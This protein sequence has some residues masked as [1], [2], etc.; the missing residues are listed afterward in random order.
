M[1]SLDRLKAQLESGEISRRQFVQGATALG[2]SASA[3]G[4]LAYGASAQ[5]AT[6]DPDDEEDEELEEVE[7]VTSITRA[8]YIAML[9]EYYEFEP[10]E[11]EGGQ[12]IHTA[13][14]DIATLNPQLHSDIISGVVTD[15]MFH[16]LTRGSAIDGVQSP[17]LADYWEVAS[18]G[19]TYTFHLPE[20]AM[21][22]DGTPLTADDV[23]FSFDAMT[24]ESSLSP[25]HSTV[26]QSLDSYRKIDDH[27]VE[28]V[29]VGQLATFLGD[30]CSNTAIVPMHIWED[31]PLDEWGSAPGAT[32]QDPEQVI[33][34]GPMTFVEWV[35][36]DHVTVQRDE[37]YWRPDE[38]YHIDQF[39]VQII[40]ESV[41]RLNSLQTGEVDSGG[42]DYA[43]VEGV[44]ESNPELQ[45]V[46]YDSFQMYFYYPHNEIVFF[47]DRDVRRALL[48]A[49]D[50][51]LLVETVFEG[52]AV[53]ADGSQPVLS[54][55]Y[56]PDQMTTIYDY[57]PDHARQLLADAGWED[58]DGDGV[59]ENED[60][61][62]FSFELSYF[63]TSATADAMIPYMQEA[64]GEIGVEMIPSS[65]PVSTVIDRA[66]A[67]DYQMAMGNFNWGSDPGQ[68]SMFRTDAADGSGFNRARFANEDYDR[69]DAE[70]R[71]E[72]DEDARVDLI[73]EQTDI[74]NEEVPIG[75]IAFQRLISVGSPR[76]RNYMPNAYGTFWAAPYMWLDDE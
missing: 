7:P 31:V 59:V 20:E 36:N 14:N 19:I 60:G 52:F 53:R 56:A 76:I 27:T 57:D 49:L 9:E 69:L 37:D 41:S 26:T 64:W 28:M 5:D 23:I 34:S 65:M 70:Q 75:V 10:A 35:L 50:R 38:R 12:L 15:F 3:A 39:I 72:L 32:G 18:D 24:D 67:G 42:A 29:S 62:R 21:W 8:E 61:E 40:E 47:E 63:E 46:D 68:G 51:D 44:R 25:R 13:G 73:I 48:H 6:P 30:V 4:T 58:R 66:N 22:H 43:Q 11:T 16:R 2:I 1:T 54:P 17:D 55:A 45:I 33:G 71:Q 74:V